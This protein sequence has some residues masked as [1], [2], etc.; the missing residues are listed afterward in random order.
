MD[1]ER[2][3]YKQLIDYIITN[4]YITANYIVDPYKSTYLFHRS[5]EIALYRVFHDINIILDTIMIA[6]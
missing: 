4:E 5:T 2:D 3:V 6:S 1:V